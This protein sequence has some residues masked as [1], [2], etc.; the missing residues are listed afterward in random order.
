MGVEGTWSSAG[1]VP[2]PR[3]VVFID[4]DCTITVH[5]QFSMLQ[6]H[7]NTESQEF[8]SLLQTEAQRAAYKGPF[9]TKLHKHYT[10]WG[11]KD[12]ASLA[13]QLQ[14]G[15]TPHALFDAESECLRDPLRTFLFGTPQRQEELTKLLSTLSESHLEVVVLTKGIASLAMAV[16][17]AFFPHWL[18]GEAIKFCD[19]S[20]HLYA[21]CVSSSGAVSFSSR[22]LGATLPLGNKLDQI[23][24]LL[25]LLPSDPGP[26]GSTLL[27]PP[28]LLIDDGFEGEL[29]H[30][31]DNCQAT[32]VPLTS[33]SA[34]LSGGAVVR[35]ELRVPLAAMAGSVV[36]PPS[37][38]DAPPLTA[39]VPRDLQVEML[40][41]GPPKNGQ[42]LTAAD[43][44]VVLD[45]CRGL[46]GVK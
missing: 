46:S 31:P 19:Y 43:M 27:C 13:Q 6:S 1:G 5:H 3:G 11:R 26:E 4:W 15:T 23:V 44:A 29:R 9:I 7:K 39:P 38:H 42:G 17:F 2:T 20:G 32:K 10:S 18:Q 21:P 24:H 30:L 22:A 14:L 40:L 8:V 35:L 45:L 41:G 33:G 12:P 28:V 25:L 36:P 34:R 16:A 37:S